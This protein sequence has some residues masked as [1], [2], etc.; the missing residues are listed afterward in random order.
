MAIRS[1]KDCESISN[2]ELYYS[3]LKDKENVHGIPLSPKIR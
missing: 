2:G 3:L 1:E